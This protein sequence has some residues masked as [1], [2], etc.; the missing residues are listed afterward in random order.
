MAR[1][2]GNRARRRN[3]NRAER[4]RQKP[5]AP[6]CPLCGSEAP[7][8]SPRLHRC[9]NCAVEIRREDVRWAS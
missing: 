2:S 4:E 3:M 8:V 1:R 7:E 6:N 5:A 9:S